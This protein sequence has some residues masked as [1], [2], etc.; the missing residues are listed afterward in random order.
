MQSFQHFLKN[1]L[2]LSTLATVFVLLFGATATMAQQTISGKVTAAPKGEALFLATVQVKGT[3]IGTTTDA[4]GKYSLAV[5]ASA[6][7]LV[8]SYTGYLSSELTIDG[9]SLDAVLSEGLELNNITVIGSRNATRT[10]LETSSAVDVIPVS[11]VANEMGQVDIQQ[12][13]TYV[14]PSFQSAR[15]TVSDGTD[16]VDPAALRGLGPDQVLVL[17]NGKRRHQTALVNVNGTTNRGTVGTDMNAI[18][19]TAIERIEIL[20]DGAAAQYGSDAIAGVIN[21]VLKRSTKQLSGNVSYG[22]NVTAYDKN[23]AWNKLNPNNQLASKV[24]VMDGQTAQVG[25]NYGIDIDKGKGFINI[26]GEYTQRAPT[27]RTG[28]YTGTLYPNVNGVNR[29]DS[30]MSARG[31]TR[32][33]FDMRIGNSGIRGGGIVVNAGYTINKHFDVY[34]NGTFNYKQGN[35]AGFYRYPNNSASLPS[36]YPNG[37]LPNINTR[38]LDLSNTIGVRGEIAKGWNYDFS[39]SNGENSFFFGVS[40][41]INASLGATSQ[42]KFDAGGLQFS[43]NTTNLDFNKNFPTVLKGLVLSHAKHR[44]FKSAIF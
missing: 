37:F 24:S 42:T 6:R 38:I 30:I 19:V 39:N 41:S 11:A 10:R 12:I 44:Y 9:A 33:D 29:D 8:F 17:V 21:I 32:N 3:T 40:N 16:H 4:D 35:A 14:A 27:S 18:P 26:T 22:S 2:G 36:V 28:L 7:V 43:Q 25:L 23:Y 31:L 15:Q 20:R 5:P 34:G 13:L 1:R